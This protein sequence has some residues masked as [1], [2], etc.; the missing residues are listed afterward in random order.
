MPARFDLVTL[1]TPST[2]RLADFYAAALDLVEVERE[3]GDRWVVLADRHGVRR[4]GFQRGPHRAGGVH[5][6]L[7]VSG[8]EL[9]REVDRLVAL[10]AELAAA[11]R[12]EPYG[13]IANLIDPA[14]NEL[15]LVA[16]E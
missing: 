8:D 7:V 9:D 5:L 6:D 3:D 12:G 14:G 2:G 1:T 4:L 16:Y 15:D 11:V 13:R 10:G